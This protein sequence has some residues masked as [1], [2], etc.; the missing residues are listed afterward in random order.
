MSR[1][2]WLLVGAMSSET[3]PV[4]RR[5]RD[6]RWL[7]PRLTVGTLEG[8]SVA[9]LRSGVGPERAHA[10]TVEA[11]GRVQA[12]RLLSFGTCGALADG[13]GVG[14]IVSGHTLFSEDREVARIEPISGLRGAGVATVAAAVTTPERRA[15]LAP[16]ADVCEMEAAAVWRAAGDR[17]LSVLKVVSDRAGADPGEGLGKLDP[18][19]VLRFQLLSLRLIEA[20][21]VPEIARLVRE[22]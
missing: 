8:E 13:L 7:S 20:R 14:A 9:L 11:L 3:L 1:V 16:Y 22:R 19:A 4:L 15:I 17:P 2:D 10:R 18:R 12:G 6:W 21:L 5:M